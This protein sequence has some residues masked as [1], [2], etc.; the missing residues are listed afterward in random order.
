MTELN[1]S[2]DTKHKIERLKEKAKTQ[3]S[4]AIEDF[5]GTVLGE[6][7]REFFTTLEKEIQRSSSFYQELAKNIIREVNGILK[8][9]D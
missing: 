4:S 3:E 5:M 8:N 2:I 7:H 9:R 1:D 6:I